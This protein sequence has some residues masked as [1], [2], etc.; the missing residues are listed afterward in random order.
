MGKSS[1]ARL[2]AR[3]R[4]RAAH[5]EVDD[6]RR[7]VVS[8]GVAPWKGEEGA[9]QQVLGVR[10][11]C[12]LATAFRAD[13]MD[14]V[15]TDVVTPVTSALYR[16]LIVDCLIVHLRAPV[17]E[18]RRRALTRPVHLTPEEF[19]LLHG[20]DRHRPPPADVVVEVSELTLEEQVRAVA[21]LWEDSGS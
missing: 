8:G 5:I 9:R 4:P 21:D 16:S 13:G 11:A 15:M 2:L 18:A 20:Q 19:D 17:E 3:T 12:A 10:N 14:V 6:L 1:T 7:L